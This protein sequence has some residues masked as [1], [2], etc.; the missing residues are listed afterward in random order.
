MPSHPKMKK[1]NQL[2]TSCVWRVCVHFIFFSSGRDDELMQLHQCRSATTERH[3]HCRKAFGHIA[4]ENCQAN[5]GIQIT[6]TN[7]SNWSGGQIRLRITNV[8]LVFILNFLDST[9]WPW[10]MALVVATWNKPNECRVDLCSNEVK[11][12]RLFWIASD[13]KNLSILRYGSFEAKII[14]SL[15]CSMY[16]SL[17]MER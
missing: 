3:K 4:W 16:E 15:L 1:K 12:Y 13:S 11:F 2:H 10:L 8:Y 9:R 14:V 5:D 7:Y 6:S 17:T